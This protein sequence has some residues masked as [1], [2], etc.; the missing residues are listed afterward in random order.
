[1]VDLQPNR[2]EK[3]EKPEKL[4]K[5]DRQERFT[6][7]KSSWGIWHKN[8]VSFVPK[9]TVYLIYHKKEVSLNKKRRR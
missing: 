4:M 3:R 1:V 6:V 8:T 5:P 7:P 2:P 9:Y